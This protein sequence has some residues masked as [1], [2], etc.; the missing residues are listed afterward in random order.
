MGLLAA[1]KAFYYDTGFAPNRKFLSPSFPLVVID[2]GANLSPA[3]VKKRGVRTVLAYTSAIEM[4]QDSRFYKKAI[5]EWK[6]PT[7]GK[8]PDWDTWFMDMTHDLWP[9]FY[10]TVIVDDAVKKGFDGIILD[11]F[12]MAVDISN[13]TGKDLNEMLGCMC[14]LVREVRIKYPDL[15]IVPNRGFEEWEIDAQFRD[16]INGVLVES[17]RTGG[18][19][20]WLHKRVKWVLD[21]GKPVLAIEYTKNKATAKQVTK[22][23]RTLGIP[24][25]VCAGQSLTP[26]TVVWY[27][28]A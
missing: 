4:A 27:S 6:I 7:L 20:K 16:D 9:E 14:L 25:L 18:D 22:D 10:R 3:Q 24:T 12:D 1:P 26:P 23:N 8:N 19:F 13:T 15:I 11:T 17:Y 5:N 21:A 28:G 2:P